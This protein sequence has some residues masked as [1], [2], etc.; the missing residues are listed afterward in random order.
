MIR[1][2]SLFFSSHN[3]PLTIKTVYGEFSIH[4][5]VLKELIQAPVMQRLKK[6]H[7]YGPTYIVGDANWY[8]RY[9]HS[10]GVFVLLRK[11]GR[12]LHEQ[13]AGLLHDASHTAFSHVGDHFIA[14]LKNDRPT[15]SY[16]E[17]KDSYQDRIHK[18]ALTQMGTDKILKKYGMSLDDVLHKNKEFNCLEAEYPHMCCDRVEYNLQGGLVRKLITQEQ[19]NQ[20]LADLHFENGSWFFTKPKFAKQFANLSLV[21]TETLWGDPKGL[22]LYD[23]VSEMMQHAVNKNMFTLDDVHFSDDEHLWDILTINNDPFLQAKTK[24]V[25]NHHNRFD[26]TTKDDYDLSYKSKFRGID[27]YVKQ[28]NNLVFLSKINSDF[29]REYRRVKKVKNDGYFLKLK[30]A[31]AQLPHVATTEDED[32]LCTLQKQI[33]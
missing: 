6:V 14:K 32:T 28:G 26:L 29:A 9:D 30:F 16:T 20:I 19:L 12:P 7:Q 31:D 8:S 33:A 1:R 27:P 23:L 17:T 11:F 13:I 2:A 10:V 21:M 25:F 24:E 4:E 5:P 22:Y 3:K 15:K 18:W